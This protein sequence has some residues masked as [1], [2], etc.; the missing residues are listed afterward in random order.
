MN[1]RG[2]TIIELVLVIIVAAIIAAVAVPKFAQYWAGIKAGSAAAKIASDIRYAQNRATTTQQRTRVN[3]TSTTTYNIQSCPFAAPYNTTTCK[4]PDPA[5]NQ[6][7]YAT[8]P[9]GGGIFSINL[10]TSTE[11]VDVQI[12]A[13]PTWLEFDS[14]GKPYVNTSGCSTTGGIT[15]T[16]SYSSSTKT[17]AVATQTGMVSVN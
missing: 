5:D 1:N 2:F 12:S 9:L 10:S 16:V 13:M 17:I 7:A 14:L 6:W 11:F 8:N 15:F 3:F 4:C